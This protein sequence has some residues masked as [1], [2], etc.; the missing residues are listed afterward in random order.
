L[1]TIDRTKVRDD[2]HGW[3]ALARL[4]G[5]YIV[6]AF[7]I[8]PADYIAL[9]GQYST[10]FLVML[11][12][13][14]VIAVATIAVMRNPVSPAREMHSVVGEYLVRAGVVLIG[15]LFFIA[16]FTTFK[17][18]IPHV[19][20][21]YADP[22]LA[23]M[24]QYLHGDSPWQILHRHSPDWIGPV[25]DFLYARVWFIE[26]FGVLAF[27]AF[28]HDEKHK[29]RYLWA[30]A[31]TMII[32]GTIVA[33]AFSSVGPVFYDAFYP[34]GRY[35]GLIHALDTSPDG[36]QVLGYA[37]YLFDSLRSNQPTFGTGISAF[38]SM[39]VAIAV[40]NAWFLS[41]RNRY[42]GLAGWAFAV[43]ILFG[44]VYTGWHYA[45]DGYASIILVS[46]IWWATGRN[47]SRAPSRQ[48]MPD[49]LPA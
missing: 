9:L 42:L 45:M 48:T 27:V 21:F 34:G 38:P 14:I 40:L 30:F 1:S 28:W 11:P 49:A 23:D 19:V 29:L 35:S 18:N 3:T 26:W 20:P 2:G 44:S 37:A 36:V 33:T 10:M 31:L 4:C 43:A 39:H 12:A 25:V 32:C 22:Y 16:A 17:A 8:W 7:I 13:V 6:A 5:A 46:V 15:F 47:W 24:G 41:G